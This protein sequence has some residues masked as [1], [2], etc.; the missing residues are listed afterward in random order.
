[1]SNRRNYGNDRGSNY[2]SNNYGGNSG[3]GG[4]FNSV[5]NVNPWQSG[6][7]PAR[8][9]GAAPLAQKL[10]SNFQ[11]ADSSVAIATLLSSILQQVVYFYLKLI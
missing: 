10:M 11:P 2:G 9:A 3:G 1:M 8:N 5:Q 7:I 4:R 6:S